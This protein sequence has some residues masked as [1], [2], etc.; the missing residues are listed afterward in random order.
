[1]NIKKFPCASKSH[2]GNDESVQKQYTPRLNRPDRGYRGN[3]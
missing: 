2:D 1:M 3:R